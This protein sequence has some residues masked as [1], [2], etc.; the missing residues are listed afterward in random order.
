VIKEYD[1]CLKCTI[2]E[3]HCPM[4]RVA[5]E[6]P[7][8]K[9]GGPGLARLRAAGEVAELD[10]LDLCLGCR[11]CDTVCPSGIQPADLIAV[12]KRK[13]VGR[14]GLTL[15]DWVLTHT[16]MVGPI[17]VHMPG[18]TN[19]V[20]ANRPIRWT[21][22]KVLHIDRHKPMPR[23]ANHSF[24][25]WFARHESPWKDRPAP[26]GKVAYFHG[27]SVQFMEPHIGRHVVEV[28]EHNG[29][30][31]VL[32]Q[33]TCCGLPIIAN[34]DLKGASSNG[35]YNLR[36]LR[37]PAE[38]GIPI[39]VSSTSCSLTLKH[40]YEHLLHLDGADVVA[41]QVYDISEFLLACHE[42]GLLRTDFQQ[43]D[44]RLPYHQPCHQR[45]QGI[46][47]P[48]V[49][50][51]NLIPGVKSWNL[52]A[53]CCGSAGTFGFKEEKYEVSMKVGESLRDAIVASGAPRTVSDCETCR[54]QIEYQAGTKAVHPI[55]VLWEAYG[56]G[57]R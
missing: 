3:M 56:L 12:P 14:R 34:G 49:T 55:S 53:G 27:C 15:R 38:A 22:E 43:M 26:N 31:V 30:E 32:P 16:Y 40:D 11:T 24:R 6:F 52:D 48:A 50:L 19:G 10:H 7:G 57:R 54:W 8:P 5:P 29:F 51:M 47:L 25:D 1:A 28:L 17:A 20:L 46:G 39:V 18:L 35:R 33:Q 41:R 44:E 37:E 9:N 13:K 4:L 23:Y 21:M 2:C 42:Q 45:A 36:H